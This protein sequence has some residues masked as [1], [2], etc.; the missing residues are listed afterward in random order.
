ML[1]PLN[2]RAERECSY[3]PGLACR[4]VNLDS[5]GGVFGGKEVESVSDL[6]LLFGLDFWIHGKGKNLRSRFFSDTGKSPSLVT[7][8]AV[9]LLKMERYGIMDPRPY[10]EC[11][12]ICSQ[13]IPFFA[14]NHVQMVDGICRCDSSC[15]RTT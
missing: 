2:C 7:E 15:G 6:A 14:A 1:F 3:A 13:L 11:R 8:P 4:C 12:E 10:V 9:G 5:A